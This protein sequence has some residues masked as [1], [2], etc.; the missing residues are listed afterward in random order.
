[1]RKIAK[2]Y[3]W[4]RNHKYGKWV[5]ALC[6][7]GAMLAAAG[8]GIPGL[9]SIVGYIPLLLERKALIRAAG[10]VPFPSALDYILAWRA[11]RVAPTG[12]ARVASAA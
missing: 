6:W 3:S 5:L 9:K 11:R 1:M 12:K 8:S 2:N 4:L 10:A 7:G